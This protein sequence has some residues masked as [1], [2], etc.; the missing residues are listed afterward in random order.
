MKIVDICKMPNYNPKVKDNANS[1][2][3]GRVQIRTI[4]LEGSGYGID[5]LTYPECVKHG[6]MNRVSKEGIWRCLADRCGVGCF[7]VE[8]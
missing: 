5:V 3:E 1:V 8:E 6:A 7:E 2:S 4:H